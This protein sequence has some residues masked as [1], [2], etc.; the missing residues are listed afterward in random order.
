MI[1]LSS[2]RISCPSHLST[3]QEIAELDLR[4][5][6]G[7][8]THRLARGRKLILGGVS[9]DF[10]RGLIGHSDADVLLHAITDALLG[11]AG[12]GDI[13]EWFSDRDPRWAGAD[14]AE[15]LKTVVRE[16]A[17]RRW[18]IVNL[19]C[20][21]SAEQPRL[22]PHKATIRGRIAELL[23]IPAE[24]VNVKAKT[25]EGVGPVGRLEA[26]EADAVVLLARET[27]GAETT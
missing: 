8:D 3:L 4:V 1:R 22:S 23:E 24:N 10:E 5:G 20:T 21:I 26:I 11:A 2:V 27:S 9:V 15:L 17:G 25:G 16:V 6:H 13:G 12:L 19:D 18:K 14:S 7:R